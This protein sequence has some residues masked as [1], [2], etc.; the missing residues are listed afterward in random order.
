MEQLILAVILRFIS[1]SFTIEQRLVRIQLLAKSL[2]GEEVAWELI[3]ILSTTLGITSHYVIA[4]MRDRASVN[5]VA[6]R[7]LKILYPHL[8][9]IG[10]FSHTLNL[11]GDHFKLPQ[12]TEFLNSWLS[13]FSHSTKT[14][15][16]WK[17]QTGRAMATYSQTRWWSKWEVM[18]QLLVQFGDIKPFL[19]KNSDI[20]PST[21][22]KLLFF[23]DDSQKLNH[24]KIELAAVV[25][26]GE[27][28]V[29]ATYKLEGDVHLAF[30]CYEAIQEVV[31]S[32]EVAN[33][34]N[35]QAVVRDISPSPTVQETLIAHAEQCIQPGIDYFNHQ[36]GT[37]LKSPLLAFRASRMTNPSMIR[38]LNLD[39]S[40]L[41]FLNP[42]PLLLLKN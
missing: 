26:W 13:L 5:N 23:F 38:N 12:L 6:I 7:T 14:K 36:L 35:V 39:A 40:S 27:P 3:N 28:F 21:R 17:E 25:D 30:T 4:T 18:Q 1:D 29:K 31:T 24:L 32:I 16:L 10:C 33:I 20:G 15:F 42:F 41:D 2:N 37:S 34:P 8:L 22:P 19:V 9:D 11:V